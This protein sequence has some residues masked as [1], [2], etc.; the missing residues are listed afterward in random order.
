M[1][2]PP[3]S[4]SNVAPIRSGATSWTLRAKNSLPSA[5]VV[6]GEGRDGKGD[7]DGTDDAEEATGD[8]REAEARQRGDQSGLDVA[9]RGRRRDLRELDPGDATA[10]RVVR[11]R[12]EN[13]RAEVGAY[14][15]RGH[16]GG[17]QQQG[18]PEGV[19]EPE[20]RDRRPPERRCD[21]HDQPLP[22]GVPDPAREHRA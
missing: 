18:E 20:G 22:A 13:R 15:V 4:T 9:E 19:R 14:I 11:D 6:T 12:P 3:P 10:E 1:R 2:P 17:E 7:Q 16:W 21:G 5:G 8:D